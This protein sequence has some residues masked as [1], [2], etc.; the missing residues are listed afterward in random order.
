M[1]IEVLQAG[2]VDDRPG[3]GPDRYY[4]VGI[5]PSGALD[6]YS[7]LAANLLVGNAEGAAGL[8]CVYHGPGAA[9]H[10]ADRGGGGRRRD[11]ARSQRRGARRS[12][13]VP[14]GDGRRRSTS[15]T[16][17]AGARAYIGGRR[18]DRR[19]EVLGSRS[20]YALGA[21]GGYQG[22][23]LQAGD[24]LPTADD[25]Q[26]AQA[27]PIGAGRP[28]PHARQGGRGPGRDGPVRPPPDRGG[29]AHVPGD[30]PGRSRRWPTA[31]ASATRAPSWSS[32]SGSRRSARA[33]TRRTSSTRR[34]PIGSIQIPG[35]VE[36]IVLHRDAVSGGGY[37]HGGHRDQR[38][39]GH[40]GAVGRR[41]PDPV[42]ARWT[43]TGRWS[44]GGSGPSASAACG[45]SS[46][47]PR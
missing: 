36:P 20:T 6:Q 8:E 18:R 41:G 26:G 35:G 33:A 1:P 31:S 17:T 44:R 22:R 46:A 28:A 47:D 14:G 19:A 42:R 43:S 16:S 11:G 7:L 24:A 10:G 23:P 37:V 34:Y 3:P 5:P 21:L 38:R 13:S 39:H 2:P 9:L 15:P 27:G 25:A 12:G 40:G 32:S 45:P 29:P 30:R 4:D